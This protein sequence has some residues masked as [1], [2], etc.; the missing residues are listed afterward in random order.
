L[1]TAQFFGNKY[2]NW[3]KLFFYCP[4]LLIKL[5]ASCTHSLEH[6]PVCESQVEMRELSV[7]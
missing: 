3:C 6:D 1:G 2:A 7:H 4:K 5:I